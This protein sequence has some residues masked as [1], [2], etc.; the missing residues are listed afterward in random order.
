MRE[1]DRSWLLPRYVARVQA[2]NKQTLQ[3]AKETRQACDTEVGHYVEVSR[4]PDCDKQ[5]VSQCVCVRERERHTH[6]ER[7]SDNER[8]N[9]ESDDRA[10]PTVCISLS[11][12][13]QPFSLI[14]ALCHHVTDCR[15][16]DLLASP[17]NFPRSFCSLCPA[18]CDVSALLSLLFCSCVLFPVA[19]R[20]RRGFGVS[21]SH[22]I[23]QPIGIHGS[24]HD[25]PHNAMQST[26]GQTT[27]SSFCVR[28]HSIEPTICG[29]SFLCV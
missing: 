1:R 14:L 15:V 2:E 25:T 8:K 29:P 23:G 12:T 9:E 24:A 3:T 5:C 17:N 26:Q 19:W 18:S 10:C 21:L 13:Y 20:H 6:R 22:A 11:F 27:V 28:I 4:P 7:E 16:T